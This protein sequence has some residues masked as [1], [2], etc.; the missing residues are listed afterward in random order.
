M[1]EFDFDEL[2][3]AVNLA[4][5][6]TE[7]EKEARPRVASRAVHARTMTSAR[8]ARSLGRTEA[9]VSLE[10]PT[11]NEPAENTVATEQPSVT[12]LSARPL[13]RRRSGRFMD[14]V[15][16]SSDMKKNAMPAR[17]L[18]SVTP[19]SERPAVSLQ[20]DQPETT[21]PETPAPLPTP[22]VLPETAPPETLAPEETVVAAPESDD[23][24]PAATADEPEMAFEFEDFAS[25]Q[26][27]TSP[28]LTDAQVEKRPLGAR[29]A[30]TKTEAEALS[31]GAP[32]AEENFEAVHEEAEA[33]SAPEAGIGAALQQA[34]EKEL[35]AAEPES[36]PAIIE[37]AE[38][39]LEETTA[40]EEAPETLA[41]EE[42]AEVL[43]IEEFDVADDDEDEVET[44]AKPAE[45]TGPTSIARQYKEAPVVASEDDTSAIFDPDSYQQPLEQEPKKKSGMVVFLILLL[46]LL[47]V[48]AA[49]AVF[50]WLEILVVP[51]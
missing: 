43:E 1:K 21:A 33:T 11:A 30:A 39:T 49:I 20:A 29:L 16:P 40:P 18:R 9:P 10:R 25:N 17:P 7:A 37:E 32:A 41:P 24:A 38:P 8:P 14:V 46:L 19:P 45:P 28:F 13:A 2:D 34:I 51:L 48:G 31:S 36:Q 42:A 44:P 23:T 12:T 4:L 5:K 47:L 6:D 35:A 15:H 3:R 22:I 26:P 27:Q 50:W